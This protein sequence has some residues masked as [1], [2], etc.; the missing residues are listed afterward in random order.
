MKRGPTKEAHEGV[1]SPL[2]GNQKRAATVD[3]KEQT[4]GDALNHMRR[5]AGRSEA[6]VKAA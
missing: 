1:E 6:R 4:P 2:K 3:S 5:I